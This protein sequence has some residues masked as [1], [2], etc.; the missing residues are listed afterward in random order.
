MKKPEYKLMQIPDSSFNK[1][2]NLTLDLTPGFSDCN[3]KILT[4]IC[5]ISHQSK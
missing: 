3:L 4:L 1:H 2:N 5:L